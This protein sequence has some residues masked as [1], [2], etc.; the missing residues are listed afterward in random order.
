MLY[1]EI[2]KLCREQGIS[3][4]V[5]ERECGI[6]NGV[7]GKWRQNNPSIRNLC[8]VSAALNVPIEDLCE[9]VLKNRQR[10]QLWTS[11]K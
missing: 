9:I 11:E 3:I 10:G 8:A 1:D 6:G 5:L 7:I 4:S 2:K